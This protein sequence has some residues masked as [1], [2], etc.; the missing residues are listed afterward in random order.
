MPSRKGWLTPDAPTLDPECRRILI[1]ANEMFMG[2]VNGALLELTKAYNWEKFGTMT[3]EEAASVMYDMWL[4]YLDS[5][6][7]GSGCPRGW[8]I[9]IDGTIEYT[10]DGGE[11]WEDG[12]GEVYQ[13]LQAR[14]EATDEEKRCAASANAVEVLKQTYLEVL[15][16]FQETGS[17]QL[18]LFAFSSIFALLLAGLIVP[19]AAIAAINALLNFTL[20]AFVGAL[21]GME[22]LSDDDWTPDFNDEMVCIL[23]DASE[24]IDGK[25]IF[26]FETIKQEVLALAGSYDAALI[27][28]VEYMLQIVGGDG[29]NVAG[30]TTSVEDADCAHCALEIVLVAVDPTGNPTTIVQLSPTRWRVTAGYRAAEN[31][32]FVYFKDDTDECFG[33]RNLTFTGTSSFGSRRSMNCAGVWGPVTNGAGSVFNNTNVRQVRIGTQ[34]GAWSMEFDAVP[35]P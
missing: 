28:W 2:A 9:G 33:I 11:T 30:T 27:F 29:L 32:Y 14:P 31:A 20:Q 34:A 17:A 7:G 18:A 10:E 35:Y 4:S 19:V 6:C 16:E 24:V 13:P 8:R 21:A 12:T 22:T 3:P 1:P 25:V 5:D 15:E 26:Q 23:L